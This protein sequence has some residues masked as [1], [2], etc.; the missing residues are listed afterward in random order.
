MQY[1]FLTLD[2]VET[3]GKRVLV[4]ADLNC[5]LDPETKEI[6]D[7]S[8]IRATIP[9][10]KELADSKVVLMAHQGRPGSKDFVSLNQHADILRNLGF[11]ITFVRDIFG[12]EA[13]RAIEQVEIGEILLLENVRMFEG[14][15][16]KGPP[17]VVAAEPIVRELYSYFDLFVNDAFGA[18]HRSQPTLVGFTVVLP[19]VAGRLVEREI[20]VLTKVLTAD[21]HPWLLALGGAKVEDKVELMMRLLNA[22]RADQVVVGGMVGTLFM[23]ADGQLSEDYLSLIHI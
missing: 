8:R 2:D 15:M 19:S 5:S 1:S 14:E 16:K 6:V 4:R 23:V 20:K 12:P 11:N 17:E 21:E 18:A 7:D 10:L 13:K 22:N 3:S 9:T